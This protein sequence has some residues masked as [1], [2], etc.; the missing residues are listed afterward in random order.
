M[1]ILKQSAGFAS[2]ALAHLF[3]SILRKS[4]F[5]EV[6]KISRIILI[7]KPGKPLLELSSYC[8][9]SN[10]NSCEYIIKEI[11]KRQ[12]VSYLENNY[13]IS[14]EH[15]GGREGHSTI[16]AKAIIDYNIG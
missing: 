14:D 16:T 5:S 9:I 8:P 3:N 6:F 10:I 15:H 11:M 7:S 2:F 1:Q 12:I 13:F 4:K